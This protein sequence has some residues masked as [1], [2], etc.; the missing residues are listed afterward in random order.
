MNAAEH[1]ER[2]CSVPC[3]ELVV[4]DVRNM[5]LTRNM[6]RQHPNVQAQG[7]D[8]A[9]ASQQQGQQRGGQQQWS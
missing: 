4:A 7:A 3:K 1:E 6:S 5:T 9:H 2:T 8:G